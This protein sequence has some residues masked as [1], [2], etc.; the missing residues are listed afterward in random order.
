MFKNTII[1]EFFTTI[2]F[3]VYLETVWF[4]SYKLPFIR[5]WNNILEMENEFLSYIWNTESKI[6][7]FYNARSAIYHVLKMINVKETDEIIVSWYNCVSVSNAVIQSWAKIIYSDIDEV[8]LWLN[9]KE[10]EKNISKNTKAI[11]IQHTF[12]KPAFI[13]EIVSLAK[14]KNIL[15]I[16]DCA[17]SL[18]SSVNWAKLWSFGDFSIFSTGRDKVISWV[19]GWFLI[20][21]NK[22]YFDK[23]E[24]VKS[25]QIIP[26]R[27]LT[28][29]NLFYNISAY[30]AYKLYDFF[31]LWKIIIYLSRKLKVIT[32]ILTINEKKCN[33]RDFNYKLPNSLAY[34]AKKQLQ[35]INEINNHR[36]ALS[37][38]YDKNI[39]NKYFRPLFTRIESE[40]NNY[41]RYPIIVKTEELKEELYKYMKKN[42]VLLWNTW[43]K[44][45]IV[46]IWTNLDN[47]K[48][49]PWSCPI[50]EDISKRI[51]ILPNHTLIT[52]EYTQKI[53]KLLNN[54]K[55]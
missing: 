45:N 18:W 1:S 54:F 39:N 53:V 3:S 10:L 12:W 2:N 47:A 30:K 16:E 49:I 55:K 29:Q 25:L 15:V 22:S 6:I 35:K 17:H 43:S 19:T 38:Y 4:L 32:E 24:L 52:V 40:K 41:F 42:N 28:L 8:N 23:I 20:I 14:E 46:P 9:I 34:L 48:Y 26:S 50:S 31:G 13:K 33:F 7:S 37:D 44:T 36:I 5:Y 11:I 27:T 51:L 21:N